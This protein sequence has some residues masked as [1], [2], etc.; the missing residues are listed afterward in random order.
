MSA[1]DAQFIAYCICGFSLGVI[2]LCVMQCTGCFRDAAFYAE[3]DAAWKV[4]AHT[5]GWHDGRLSECEACFDAQAE[6]DWNDTQEDLRM[7]LSG[8]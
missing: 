2:V 6:H 5:D 7:F 3:R 8:Q 4:A 1:V